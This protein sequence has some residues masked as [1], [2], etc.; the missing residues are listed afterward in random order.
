MRRQWT[1]IIGAALAL[2]W[3]GTAPAADKLRVVAS[4]AD[5]AY[6]ARQ[7]GGDLA[8]VD[9]IAEGNRDLH[10][11]EVLPSYMLK[12]RKADIYLIV[13]LELDQWSAPLIDG[14]R[15]TKLRVIDCSQH[16]VPLEVP[17]FKADARYGDLHRFGNPHYWVDPDN[18]PGI[19][20]SIT[21]A[22]VAADPEHAAAYET[23]R[24]AYLARLETKKKEWDALKPEM[25]KVR[26]ISYHNTWPY[27][28]QYFGCQTA[29]F[30]EEFAGVAPSP[31][32]LAR[33]VDRIKT[34]KIPI[35]AYEPFHDRRV[36]AMLAQ[37]TGCRA[38]EL[39]S[40]VGG[41]PGT[42]TYEA[43]IDHIVHALLEANK[44]S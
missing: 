10:Y 17:K 30:V 14:S 32:H 3:L 1:G 15:N 13:G 29:G 42:G 8:T 5:L 38:I 39:G 43:L 34:E 41:E 4:T 21:E 9:A 16:I 36:P 40:S 31:S 44:G 12:L 6:F 7:I 20:R 28:N 19:C 18:V 22:F 23:A 24:D 25:A 35:V 11:I 33:M 37:K 26:F 2:M 27:F